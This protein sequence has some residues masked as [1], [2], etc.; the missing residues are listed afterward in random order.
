VSNEPRDRNPRDPRDDDRPRRRDWGDDDRPKKGGGNSTLLILGIVGGVLLLVC[1]GCGIGG[2][3]I[4]KAAEEKVQEAAQ[5]VERTNDLHQVGIAYHEYQGRNGRPP[6]NVDELAVTLGS[7]KA[8]QRIRSGEI[9]VIWNV[10][11]ARQFK[12][13]SNVILAFY[14]RPEPNGDRI[15]LYADGSTRLLTAPEFNSAA[16]AEPTPVK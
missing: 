15:A 6:A 11:P 7:G 13:T 16:R 9:E 12:G 1:A 2:F 10:N 14:T 4:Y 8:L 5:R 3:F